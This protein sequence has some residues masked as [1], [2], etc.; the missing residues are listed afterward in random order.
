MNTS[1]RPTRPAFG[2]TKPVQCLACATFYS[3][4]LKL[5]Q[6]HP[7]RGPGTSRRNLAPEIIKGIAMFEEPGNECWF[8]NVQ[9]RTKSAGAWMR[10]SGD[11]GYDTLRPATARGNASGRYQTPGAVAASS[12]S[13]PGRVRYR[14]EC[15]PLPPNARGWC[16]IYDIFVDNKVSPPGLTPSSP[17]IIQRASFPP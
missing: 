7:R 5:M 3:R 1:S 4:S 2:R 13:G 10:R 6:H 11:H 17:N 16:G 8:G 12:S 15:V 14:G 9:G